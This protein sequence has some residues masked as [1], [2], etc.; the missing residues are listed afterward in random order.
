MLTYTDSQHRNYPLAAW[1]GWP[2]STSPQSDPRPNLITA[3]SVRSKWLLKSAV[4][5]YRLDLPP[6][7]KSHDV[8]HVSLLT[9]YLE[10]T[11]AGRIATQPPPVIVDDQEE[12]EVDS[13][14]DSRIRYR[15][16][17][18]LVHWRGQGINDRTWEPV[19]HLANAP[20]P[21]KGIPSAVPN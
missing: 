9:P 4:A 21:I 16:L 20:I 15:K 14:L 11:F 17:E 2:E 8:F 7:M 19:E 18:Y 5:A 13:V 10:N 1:Y 12:L 6:T 3:K